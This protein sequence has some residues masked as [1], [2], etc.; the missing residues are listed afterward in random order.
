MRHWKR[1]VASLTLASSL[2][3]TG[4]INGETPEQEIFETLEKV[5]DL[6]ESFEA[7][8]APL[9]D[10]EQKEKQIYDEII[11]LGMK[12]FDQIVKLAQEGSSLVEKREEAMMAEKESI[13]AAREQFEEVKTSIESLDDEDLKKEAQSLYQLMEKRYEA[14]MTLSGHY[15]EAIQLDKELY[16]LFQKEDLTLEEL[17]LQINK[18]NELLVKIKESNQAFNEF[19]EQY[20][21]AKFSFYKNAGLNVEYKN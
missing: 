6:E 2:L 20:N 5:V 9:L 3:L 7:Q 16:A 15:M 12:E 19:T 21:E 11:T 4:C 17:Q 18:I 8:Q 10:L 14:Y 1:T 13:E